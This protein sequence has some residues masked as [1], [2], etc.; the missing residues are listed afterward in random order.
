MI[1]EKSMNESQQNVS[2]AAFD[3]PWPVLQFTL[4]ENVQKRTWVMC[5]H[6][7]SHAACVFL[8]GEI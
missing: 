4:Y 7:A 5:D 6:F 1:A 3:C 8:Y 2:V